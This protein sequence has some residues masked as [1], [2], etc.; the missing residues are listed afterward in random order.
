MVLVYTFPE[1]ASANGGCFLRDRRSAADV[2]EGH[3]Q[4]DLD[5]GSSM[6]SADCHRRR[7]ARA[8][9]ATRG[10]SERSRAI[11]S[12]CARFRA[13]AAEHRKDLCR[14][15]E[16]LCVGRVDMEA[17]RRRI[18]AS[19]R[20]RWLTHGVQ[21]KSAFQPAPHRIG[22]KFRHGG[23]RVGIDDSER[24]RREGEEKKQRR[25]RPSPVAL[26]DALEQ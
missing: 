23:N 10:K 4:L 15:Q 18:S 1:N 3:A 22:M 7:V 17:S 16:F 25:R 2:H 19:R 8:E 9:A 6:G 5:G 26:D 13:N 21:V 20:E 14:R 11:G 24:E 12:A